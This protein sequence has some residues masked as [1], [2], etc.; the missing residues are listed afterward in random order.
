MYE[1]CL[2]EPPTSMKPCFKLIADVLQPHAI[3]RV[4][5]YSSFPRVFRPANSSW[6]SF[7]RSEWIDWPQSSLLLNMTSNTPAQPQAYHYT[8]SEP[9]LRRHQD[10]LATRSS[11]WPHQPPPQ[12]QKQCMHGANT[13]ATWSRSVPCPLYPSPFS[14]HVTPADFA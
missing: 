5:F 13:A 3:D 1:S 12:S 7:P 14:A 4:C 9:H 8:V 6:T 11:T 2:S 10:Q